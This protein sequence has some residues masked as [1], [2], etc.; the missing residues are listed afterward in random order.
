VQSIKGW[1]TTTGEW[2]VYRSQTEFVM[3]TKTERE[4]LDRTI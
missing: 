4:E 3:E 1:E 2:G